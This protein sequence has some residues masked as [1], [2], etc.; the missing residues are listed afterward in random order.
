MRYLKLF[1]NIDFIEDWEEEEEGNVEIFYPYDDLKVGDEVKI[2]DRNDNIISS[3]KL[4]NKKKNNLKFENSREIFYYT[5]DFL[6]D[7]RKVI[8]L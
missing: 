2:V 7:Y 4:I 5:P 8:K 3:G 6:G 1:E